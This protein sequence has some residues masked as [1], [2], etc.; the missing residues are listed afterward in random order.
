MWVCYTTLRLRFLYSA[1]SQ[2]EKSR[3]ENVVLSNLPARRAFA[4]RQQVALREK[5][6]ER[7]YH[8]VSFPTNVMNSS[9]GMSA[10]RITRSGL[11]RMNST[12]VFT[13]MGFYGNSTHHTANVRSK[14][15]VEVVIKESWK[16]DNVL[17]DVCPPNSL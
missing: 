12:I 9:T 1:L 2:Q 17:E 11:L 5:P 10:R 3:N 15:F 8:E 4:N 7:I 14:G 16:K 6:P 13:Q